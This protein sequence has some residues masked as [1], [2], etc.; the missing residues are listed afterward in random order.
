MSL[1]LFCDWLAA[2]P[3]S[4]L[5]QTTSWVVP[6]VQT[7]HILS[8]AVVISAALLVHLNTLGLAMRSYSSAALAARFLPGLWWAVGVLLVSGS[9]L[10]IAEPARSLP[11]GIFQLKMSLLI[12]AIALTLLYQL[13]MRKQPAHWQTTPARRM[14]ARA[15]AILSLIIWCCIVFAGRW[16]AYVF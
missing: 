5:F 7:V 13:P 15:I 8:I 1:Q 12:V 3:A 14:N 9:I 10:V 4:L 6:A 2:T 16:I 11:K